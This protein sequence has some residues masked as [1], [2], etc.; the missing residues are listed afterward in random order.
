MLIF[1]IIWLC[2]T[3]NVVGFIPK[4]PDTSRTIP[5]LIEAHGLI[6]ETHHVITEDGY[7]L[8]IHRIKSNEANNTN[9]KPVIINHGLFGTGADFLVNSPFLLPPDNQSLS[10]NLPFALLGRYDVW[11]ANN[12][13]NP[14]GQSHQTLSK[15][16]R[17]FWNFSFDNMALF[18]LTGIIEHVRNVTGSE[19]VGF[20]GYSQGT[21][22]MFILLSTRPEYASIVQPFV[23]MAPIVNYR[24][25]KAPW[26]YFAPL[27]W[28]LKYF[29]GRFSMFE[30]PLSWLINWF[31]RGLP[32]LCSNGYF[33]FGGYNFK[34]LNQTRLPVYY[35]YVPSATSSW[36]FAHWLQVINRGVL[37]RFDN[38]PAWNL[39]QYGQTTAPMWNMS[40]IDSK[41][42]KIALIH[43]KGDWLAN[44]KDLDELRQELKWNDVQLVGDHQVNDPNWVHT[45]FL[46]GRGAGELVHR[47]VL[48]WLDE[49]TIDVR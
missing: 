14:Y 27:E 45:D 34:R 26:K 32:T 2:W 8:Q 5:Q 19:T 1:G 35:S 33:L 28:F 20:V 40:R 36:N 10:D 41:H 43:G 11:L 25:I 38:G 22:I 44:E 6:C 16:D 7:I 42:A 46:F 48:E 3:A 23:A 49:F 17:H 47:K 24:Y 39:K 21:T 29:S 37:Q 30:P 31:C 13:G 9:L 15:L 4:D 18:D 12:R